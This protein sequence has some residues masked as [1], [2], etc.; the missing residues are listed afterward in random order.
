MGFL[1]ALGNLIDGGSGGLSQFGAA[2]DPSGALEMQKLRQQQAEV[3]AT[4]QAATDA[5]SGQ[6]INQADALLKFAIKSGDPKVLQAGLALKAMSQGNPM[7][8]DAQ[9]KNG[10]I[11]YADY[12]KAKTDPTAM[13]FGMFNK[14]PAAGAPASAQ[15]SPLPWQTQNAA[16]SAPITMTDLPAPGAAP[17]PQPQTSALAGFAPASTDDHRNYQYLASLPPAVQGIVKGLSDG[18]ENSGAQAMKSPMALYLQSMAKSFDPS[19]SQTAFTARNKTAADF[20]SSG[21]S[22]QA[23]TSINTGTHHL[24]QVALAGLDMSTHP[25]MFGN[26]IANN[27]S[28]WGGN[29]PVTNAESTVN[30]VAPELAKAAASGGD[31]GEKD[32]EAQKADF[33]TNYSPEQWLGAAANKVQL[34]QGKAEELGNTY[35][36]DMGH[37]KEIISPEN[38]QTQKDIV[39]LHGLA[40]TGKLETPEA[41]AIIARLRVAAS[42]SSGAPPAPGQQATQKPAL[43]QASALAEARRRGLVK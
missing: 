28:R 5:S 39:A 14:Q 24:A 13:M 25:T 26:F 30:T 2:L 21:K 3:S 37:G 36:K 42:D 20:A 32:R 1:S 33:N 40:K 4:Q 18:D 43:D 12:I 29:D 7:D 6:P 17:A 11:T 22:G 41:Q 19:F 31:V 34:L 10:N 8:L 15:P 27:L 16:P 9:L 38:L 23:I 35:S